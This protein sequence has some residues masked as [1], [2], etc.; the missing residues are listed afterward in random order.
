V[1]DDNFIVSTDS[2]G[3]EPEGETAILCVEKSK[4]YA[5]YKKR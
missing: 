4:K 1:K 3:N 5:T 2:V